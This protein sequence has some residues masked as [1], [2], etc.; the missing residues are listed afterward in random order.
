M[1]IAR[2]KSKGIQ[3]RRKTTFLLCHLST[4]VNSFEGE[5]HF[6]YGPNFLSKPTDVSAKR[7]CR[8]ETS[9]QWTY[10][11]KKLR[12]ATNIRVCDKDSK[13]L[14]PVPT[15]CYT[16][17]DWLLLPLCYTGCFLFG[18][19]VGQWIEGFQID[20]AETGIL[21]LRPWLTTASH[22]HS[23]V[24]LGFCS[25]GRLGKETVIEPRKDF[26]QWLGVVPG[27]LAAITIL[28]LDNKLHQRE[29]QPHVATTFHDIQAW[30]IG[31]INI[32]EIVD[33]CAETYLYEDR[34]G[35]GIHQHT[36]DR[37]LFY[38]ISQLYSV[39]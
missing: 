39:S 10:Y 3:K 20:T 37:I 1:C 32:F 26:R 14:G 18:L 31:A 38:A 16:N 27:C 36:P 29:V 6:D 22:Q 11:S 25:L 8:I 2:E 17:S 30:T 21:F 34:P 33:R 5:S 19:D 7:D 4:I 13:R 35:G 15:G 23:Y 9:R 28:L 12:L 24:A